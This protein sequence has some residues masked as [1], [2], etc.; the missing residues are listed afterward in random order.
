MTLNGIHW[1][2]TILNLQDGTILEQLSG[3][4]LQK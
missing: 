4:Q 3:Y 1:R 2:D